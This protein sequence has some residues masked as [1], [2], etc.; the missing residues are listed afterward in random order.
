M[1]DPVLFSRRASCI[2]ERSEQYTLNLSRSQKVKL[3]K[4][5]VE[6]TFKYKRDAIW[7]CTPMVAPL[8]MGGRN[9]CC[10]VVLENNKIN[11]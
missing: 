9:V 8:L 4:Y 10:A 5:H 2:C 11:Q 7:G 6:I 3:H 1:C